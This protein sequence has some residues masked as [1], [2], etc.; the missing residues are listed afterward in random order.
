MTA[1]L[2]S[3]WRAAELRAVRISGKLWG[4]KMLRTRKVHRVITAHLVG[5]LIVYEMKSTVK[6]AGALD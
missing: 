2:Y 5:Y 3:R 4:E 6:P 1:K